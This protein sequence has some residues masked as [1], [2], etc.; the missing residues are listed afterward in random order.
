M[1][2]KF[3]LDFD[4]TWFGCNLE[5]VVIAYHLSQNFGVLGGGKFKDIFMYIIF[6]FKT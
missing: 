5:F 4:Q 3:D 2:A 1:Y 6:L